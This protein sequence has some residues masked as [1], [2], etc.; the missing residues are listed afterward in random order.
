[1]GGLLRHGQQGEGKVVAAPR[2]KQRHLVRLCHGNVAVVCPWQR[3]Q[4]ADKLKT[5]K[6][7]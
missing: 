6:N 4:W 2:A 3:S 7:L 1:M 5:R